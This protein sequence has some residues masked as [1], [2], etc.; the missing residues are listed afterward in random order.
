M[1]AIA[2]STKE[3]WIQ[4]CNISVFW[5]FL[6]Q[7]KLHSCARHQV[8]VKPGMPP[9]IRFFKSGMPEVAGGEYDVELASW[10][11]LEDGAS[12]RSCYTA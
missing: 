3:I 1:T 2:K 12:F 4:N 9:E 11:L 10:Q 6:L 5:L 7:W 8:L